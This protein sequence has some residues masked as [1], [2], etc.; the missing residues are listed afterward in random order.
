MPV[1]PTDLQ[2]NVNLKHTLTRVMR[3]ITLS[4][5][6]FEII[7]CQQNSFSVVTQFVGQQTNFLGESKG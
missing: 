6:V 1:W 2:A 7:F 5:V 3:V 4:C